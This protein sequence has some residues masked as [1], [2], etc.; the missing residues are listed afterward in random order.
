MA[1]LSPSLSHREREERAKPAKGEGRK[2]RAVYKTPF[3][4]QSLPRYRVPMPQPPT[5]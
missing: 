5:P 2:L 3:G 1:T 4:A